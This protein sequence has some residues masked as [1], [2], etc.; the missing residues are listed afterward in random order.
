M[1]GRLRY[2]VTIQPLGTDA[3]RQEAIARRRK[4]P[5]VV[6]TEER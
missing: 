1:A 6:D 2:L 4:L 5:G 3:A